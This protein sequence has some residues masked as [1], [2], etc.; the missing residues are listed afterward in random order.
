[1][2]MAIIVKTIGFSMD[3]KVQGPEQ[4]EGRTFAFSAYADLA[5]APLGGATLDVDDVNV[6]RGLPQGIDLENKDEAQAAAND[7]AAFVKGVM[8]AQMQP[9]LDYRAQLRKGK[10]AEIIA[11]LPQSLRPFVAAGDGAA[12]APTSRDAASP[13]GH[14]GQ[15]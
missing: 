8:A 13:A 11:G 9:F 15:E 7:L 3:V 10:Y 12:A 14:N 6:V 5:S 1:M 2:S 4:Y